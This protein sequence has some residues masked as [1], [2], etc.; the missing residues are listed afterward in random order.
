[1]VRDR[2][3]S[4]DVD[5]I[6]RAR[7]IKIKAVLTPVCAPWVNANAERVVGTPRL[8]GVASM[9]RLSESHLRTVLVEGSGSVQRQ[10]RVVAWPVPGGVH[11]RQEREAA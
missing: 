7:R 3:R 5:F 4:Y 2:D 10:G 6:R 11:R 9:I 8:E 1:M